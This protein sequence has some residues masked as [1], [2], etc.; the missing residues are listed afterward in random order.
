MWCNIITPLAANFRVAPSST[1]RRTPIRTRLGACSLATIATRA[2]AAIRNDWD[3]V[4]T[5]HIRTRTA[6]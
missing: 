1:T 4:I 6:Q 3:S 2:P 5:A